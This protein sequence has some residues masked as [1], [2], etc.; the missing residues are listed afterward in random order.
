MDTLMLSDYI[1]QSPGDTRFNLVNIPRVMNNKDKRGE[2][3]KEIRLDD[4]DDDDDDDDE[5]LFETIFV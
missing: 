4:D 1:Y 5:Y 3:M 2:T